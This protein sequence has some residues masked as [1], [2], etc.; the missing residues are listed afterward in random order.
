MLCIGTRFA[1]RT[2][3]SDHGARSTVV[4]WVLNLKLITVTL[5]ELFYVY[6]REE[7]LLVVRD[8]SKAYRSPPTHK[9][10]TAIRPARS[11][12]CDE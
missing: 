6:A 12:M 3:A 5:A 11:S 9:A 7:V 4:L 1:D 8:Y 10:A 2:D